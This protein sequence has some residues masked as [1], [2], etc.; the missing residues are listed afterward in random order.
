VRGRADDGK[1]LVITSTGFRACAGDLVTR[2]LG[3]RS[4][5]ETRQGLEA[6]TTAERWTPIDRVLIQEAGAAD[7]VIDL[8]SRWPKLA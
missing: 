1:D 3:P 7:G 2:E 6:G 5:L 8:R 4:E